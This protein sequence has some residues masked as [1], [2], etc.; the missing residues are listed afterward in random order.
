MWLLH[1]SILPT[2]GSLRFVGF[3]L[4]FLFPLLACLQKKVSAL[5]PAQDANCC[6][7]TLPGKE[8]APPSILSATHVYFMKY[9]LYHSLRAT[10]VYWNN[11]ALCL[12]PPLSSL[13]WG[14][15]LLCACQ[16]SHYV[17]HTRHQQDLYPLSCKCFP[18]S[19]VRPTLGP[20]NSLSHK[21]RAVLWHA[22]TYF[23]HN[24]VSFQSRLCN[25]WSHVI[26]C[27]LSLRHICA[28]KDIVLY[29]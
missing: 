12:Y 17:T 8:G 23:H 5:L 21:K 6:P 14:V 24:G 16:V 27:S 13:A 20:K 9:T 2:S 25:I 22:P 7:L 18:F 4:F 29:S 15:L 19:N 26:F 11:Y 10:H 1:N 3:S 28:L